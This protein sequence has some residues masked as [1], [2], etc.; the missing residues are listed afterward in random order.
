MVSKAF[1]KSTAKKWTKEL[2]GSTVIK[3]PELYTSLLLS[4]KIKPVQ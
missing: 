1:E 3:V 4:N 2:V